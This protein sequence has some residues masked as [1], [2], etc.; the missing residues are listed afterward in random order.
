MIIRATLKLMLDHNIACMQ[1]HTVK[2]HPIMAILQCC[3]EITR[4]DVL[5]IGADSLILPKF[6]Y[7]THSSSLHRV[8]FS[9]FFL[10]V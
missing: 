7:T 10:D 9:H 3:Y 5:E 4:L 2:T 6:H 1:K 8:V